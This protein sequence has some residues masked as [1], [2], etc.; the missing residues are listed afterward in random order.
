MHLILDKLVRLVAS[1]LVPIDVETREFVRG[2]TF[3]KNHHS[4]GSLVQSAGYA[5][6]ETNAHIGMPSSMTIF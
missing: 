6:V 1:G 4:E 3:F 5:F 2:R